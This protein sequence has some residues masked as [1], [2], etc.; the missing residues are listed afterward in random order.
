[1]PSPNTTAAKACVERFNQTWRERLFSI[2]RK[3][4]NPESLNRRMGCSTPGSGRRD[5]QRL[6]ASGMKP[7]DAF[8]GNP[9]PGS[10]RATDPT[11]SLKT[12]EIESMGH[13]KDQP[14][15]VLFAV[16][17]QTRLCPRRV[18]GVSQTPGC[19]S[20]LLNIYRFE[21][22]GDN[23]NVLHRNIVDFMIIAAVHS[24]GV[25]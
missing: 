10:K 11:W 22:K 12:Y 13:S 25:A 5:K 19:E 18:A 24:F 16:G 21:S 2:G 7:K 6:R 15:F 20:H 8:E 1:M 17:P 14:I 3:C 9:K 23:D 4:K